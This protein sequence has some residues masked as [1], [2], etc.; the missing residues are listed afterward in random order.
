MTIKEAKK[1]L[2]TEKEIVALDHT[3]YV[4]FL[5]LGMYLLHH[6]AWPVAKITKGF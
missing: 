5:S 3:A 2:K 6:G 4:M 1:L